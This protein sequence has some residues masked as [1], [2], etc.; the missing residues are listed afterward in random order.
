MLP[1]HDCKVETQKKRKKKNEKKDSPK[2]RICGSLRV[3]FSGFFGYFS[4]FCGTFSFFIR[5][6]SVRTS[7]RNSRHSKIMST[8]RSWE[9]KNCLV[10]R[11]VPI[12]PSKCLIKATYHDQQDSLNKNPFNQ[13]KW[14]KVEKPKKKPVPYL[15]FAVV[16]YTRC[17]ITNLIHE[18]VSIHIELCYLTLLGRRSL[19]IPLPVT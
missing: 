12:K 18:K 5:F 13:S 4:V 15:K 16:F 11:L 6:S 8:M 1:L 14:A 17:R 19:S 7:T 10:S 3:F 2:F 9:A